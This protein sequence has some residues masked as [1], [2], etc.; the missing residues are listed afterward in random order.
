MRSAS[1]RER[2]RRLFVLAGE[3]ERRIWERWEPIRGPITASSRIDTEHYRR[4]EQGLKYV[5]W[6]NNTF[7]PHVHVGISNID[8]AVRVGDRWRRAAAAAGGLCQLAL[9]RRT[10]LGLGLGT[11]AKLHAQ[12]PTL[13]HP[14]RV[15]WLAG[16]SPVHRVPAADK[17]DRGVHA[18]TVVGA[19][20]LRV[21]N[22]GGTDLRCAE[23]GGRVRGI[24]KLD[25]GA[26]GRGW[27]RP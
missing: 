17:L 20:A 4:V 5:A 23:H 19:P 15:R 18:G 7:S 27:S 10:R 6:R 9:P 14:R 25:R 24:G 13:R 8:R 21:R 2:R 11:H 26:R 12:L 22:G 3:V 1:Q 16:I